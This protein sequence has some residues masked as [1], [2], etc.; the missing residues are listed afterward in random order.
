MS[1]NIIE[2]QVSESFL[3]FITQKILQNNID[4]LF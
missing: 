3:P 1:K 4:V 2:F